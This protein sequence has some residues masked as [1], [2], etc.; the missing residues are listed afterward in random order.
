MCSPR[1]LYKFLNYFL[2]PPFFWSKVYWRSLK[3]VPI[4]ILNT[5]RHFTPPFRFLREDDIATAFHY[6]NHHIEIS[7][8]KI[9]YPLKIDST[10]SRPALITGNHK[11]IPHPVLILNPF[12]FGILILIKFY[13]TSSASIRLYRDKYHFKPIAKIYP[14]F[15]TYYLTLARAVARQDPSSLPVSPNTAKQKLF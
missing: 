6:K 14:N 4:R 9:F 5:V 3:H 10:K 7:G 11:L 2:S 15:M 13:R 12:S 8:I 1:I